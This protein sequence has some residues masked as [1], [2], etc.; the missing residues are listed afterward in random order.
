VTIS[1]QG[2]GHS[3]R[4]GC[5]MVFSGSG[6]APVSVF[7]YS[8]AAITRSGWQ[9]GKGEGIWRKLAHP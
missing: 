2:L 8:L 4:Q 9:S 7:P 3:P 6:I 5:A 1:H